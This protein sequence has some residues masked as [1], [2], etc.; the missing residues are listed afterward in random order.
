MKQRI[1][2]MAMSHSF[3]YVYQICHSLFGLVHNAHTEYTIDSEIRRVCLPEIKA[4]DPSMTDD[5]GPR[6]IQ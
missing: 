2:S 5:F 4:G 6:N 3:L 1:I